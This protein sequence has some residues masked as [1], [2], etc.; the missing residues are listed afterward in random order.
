MTLD[1]SPTHHNAAEFAWQNDDVFGRIA[2]RYDTQCDVFSFGIHR[3]WKRRAAQRIADKDW[4]ALLD[5]ATRTGDILLRV[6]PTASA[7]RRNIIASGVS[8]KWWA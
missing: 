6:L 5:G 1:H 2:S 3:L 4:T 8:L 7:Q